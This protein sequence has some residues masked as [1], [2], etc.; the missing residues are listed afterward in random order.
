MENAGGNP[1]WGPVD[2]V[3]RRD[4]TF[5]GRVRGSTMKT[6]FRGFGFDDLVRS[7]PF[8][9]R[10][11]VLVLACSTLLG[12]T[13][14]KGVMSGDEDSSLRGNAKQSEKRVPLPPMAD[15]FDIG[16]SLAADFD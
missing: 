10:M 11:A 5:S 3:P 14:L 16:E 1:K 8:A 7:L 9:F 12:C 15:D 6:P 4:P 2:V 13:A